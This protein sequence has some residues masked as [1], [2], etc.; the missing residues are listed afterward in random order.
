[1][2]DKGTAAGNAAENGGYAGEKKPVKVVATGTFDILHQGHIY[3]LTESKKLGD[4]LHV[5]VARDANVRHK[6]K[7]V[8][9]EHQRV[10]MVGALKTVDYA[11]LG[12]I[13]DLFKPIKEIDPDIITIGFNQFFDLD[14]LRDDLKKR[15]LRAKVVKIGAFEG[16]GFSSSREI[17]N[18]ILKER[19]PRFMESGG[20]G[21]SVSESSGGVKSSDAKSD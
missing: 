11:H 7:P 8:V 1:M 3:Y 13:G 5:I 15:G 14:K 10:F 18:N 17:M 21:E 19:C 20:N 2:A 6:P 9:P 16:G 12:N 4:E